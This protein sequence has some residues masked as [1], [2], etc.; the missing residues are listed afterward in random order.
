MERL[1]DTIVALA[2][3]PL[4]SAIAVLRLSGPAAIDAAARLAGLK[5]SA[6]RPG[7]MRLCWLTEGGERIDQALVVVFR[8][9]R[10]FTG[11]D[12][13]EL[14]VHGSVAVVDRVRAALGRLGVVAAAP[15]AFSRRAYLHGRL[16]LTQAEAIADLIDAES[17][18]GLQLALAAL[19]G[20]VGRALE[21][22]RGPL[23]EA[24][25]QVE[26]RLDFSTEPDIAALDESTIAPTLGRLA[27]QMRGLAATAIEGRRRL[28]GARIVLAGPPNAGK[29]S[30]LNALAAHDRALVHDRPGTTRD[31]LEV[32]ATLGG[33][34]VVW[35]DTAGQHTA[36]DPVEHA[37]IERAVQAMRAAD[38]VVW[39][40]GGGSVPGDGSDGSDGSDVV[41][42]ELLPASAPLIW[43][44]SKADLP[45]AARAPRPADPAID[46]L[47]VSAAT[48]AGLD[49]LRRAVLAALEGGADEPRGVATGPRGERVVLTR[50]RQAAALQRAAEAVERALAALGD[51]LPLECAADDLRDSLAALDEVVGQ[52]GSE[53]VLDQIFARFC[54]GK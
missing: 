4:P 54:V 39:L 25:A 38:V 30:L 41:P 50:V 7:R 22:L 8:G 33:R 37:G 34:S 1:Q 31:V 51:G 3:G 9:P 35:V 12:V 17:P 20:Q 26:A 36:S 5:P 52:V 53:D 11:E 40:L 43:V 6:L 27:A 32:P 13:A 15:G 47:E 21:Q 49:A 14:H 48:G 10:S 29:S 44:R 2:S 23:L 28:H 19:D 46:V 18:D 45:A 42:G 24:V 16:D